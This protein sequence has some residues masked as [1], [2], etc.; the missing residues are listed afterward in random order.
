MCSS[1]LY[2]PFILHAPIKV[3]IC[4]GVFLVGGGSH[5]YTNIKTLYL[6]WLNG[7]PIKSLQ[8]ELKKIEA[9]V[10][11]LSVTASIVSFFLP[12]LISPR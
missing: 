5:L 6:K 4:S 9:F 8:I 3:V 7:A 2:I 1:Q 10:Y 12:V 11:G